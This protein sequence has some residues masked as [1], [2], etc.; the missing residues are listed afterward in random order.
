MKKCETYLRVKASGRSPGLMSPVLGSSPF[1]TPRTE[2]MRSL[3]P[4]SGQNSLQPPLIGGSFSDVQIRSGTQSRHQSPPNFNHAPFSY[5]GSTS[6]LQ[7]GASNIQAPQPRP[8]VNGHPS[9]P[10]PADWIPQDQRVVAPPMVKSPSR[11]S[12]A[13][14]ASFAQS[15]SSNDGPHPFSPNGHAPVQGVRQR[16]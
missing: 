9:P 1:G 13:R 2:D 14:P 16:I 5:S 6:S 15:R 12:S 8:A 3:P 7:Q 11:P 10:N 4:R